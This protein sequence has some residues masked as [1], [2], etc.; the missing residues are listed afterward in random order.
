MDRRTISEK[1]IKSRVAH[2]E[3]PRGSKLYKLDDALKCLY[4]SQKNT[5]ENSGENLTEIDQEKLLLL[6]AKR[7]R[8][9][10][11]LQVAKNEYVKIDDVIDAVNEEYET[12]RRSIRGLPSALAI[13]LSSINSVEEINDL[14][15]KEVDDILS[16]L[17]N[18]AENKV[19][20]MSQN[21]TGEEVQKTEEETTEEILEEKEE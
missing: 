12:I 20:E 1:L 2:E 10:L 3:G 5:D 19:I 16:N 8:A 18:D 6:R 17:K 11:D 14:L 21:E 4:S 13:H 15:T 7:E 9:E